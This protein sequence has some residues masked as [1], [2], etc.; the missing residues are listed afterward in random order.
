M[1][2]H[3]IV[4]ILLLIAVAPLR[5]PAI[6][7][8]ASDE[9]AAADTAVALS[10]LEAVGDFN[11]LYDRI[12]PDAHA[13]I[14]RAAVIGWYQN[15][16]A[17]L[18]PG[19][20]T[21]TGVRFVEWTWPV[22]GQTYPY[23]AEVSFQQPLADGT[24][25]EDVVRLVQDRTGEWRWFFGRSR[26][27]VEEQ[28][29]KYVPQVPAV[30]DS[31]VIGFVVADLNT[32][33][34]ISFG[35]A[36]RTYVAPNVVPTYGPSSSSCGFIDPYLSPAAYCPIDQ[37]VYYTPDWFDY[38]DYTIGDFA[39]ITI[40]A[41]EWGHHV[42]SLEGQYAGP[43][44]E[45]ELQADC[46]AGSYARDAATRGVLDPG[47]VTEAVAI[48]AVGGDPVGLPQDEPGAHGTSDE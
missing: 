13:V 16:F 5:S 29:A 8:F 31:S 34:S 21:V 14:P 4:L 15:E 3:V 17:P 24:V 36:G 27:F 47:D 33:W 35:A 30:G 28:I 19:V 44:S 41:H 12:H 2:R 26:E 9:E 20:A 11:A 22:T 10:Y 38:F 45:H 25:L 39:W 1:S 18:G 23:T 7:Q 37:T 42:Q 43:R 6:A 40:L 48:S 32:F 46:L